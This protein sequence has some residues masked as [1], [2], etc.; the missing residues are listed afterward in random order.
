MVVTFAHL[1]FCALWHGNGKEVLHVACFAV[2]APS[3][4]VGGTDPETGERISSW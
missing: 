4:H 1:S 3:S 2:K